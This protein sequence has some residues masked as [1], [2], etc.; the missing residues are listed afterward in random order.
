MNPDR[1]FSVL[2]CS[3][4][5]VALFFA[6]AG[7]ETQQGSTIPENGPTGGQEQPSQIPKESTSPEGPTRMVLVAAEEISAGTVLDE[8]IAKMAA[9]AVD[10]LPANPIFEGEE[11]YYRSH[12]IGEDL[13]KGSVLETTI[14]HLPRREPLSTL[15]S[16]GKRSVILPVKDADRLVDDITPGDRVDI[17]F[18]LDDANTARKL[19]VITEFDAD[20][21]A[22]VSL[23]EGFV[24]H[25]VGGVHALTPEWEDDPCP[26]ARS[27]TL[28]TSPEDARTLASLRAVADLE[29]RR[30]QSKANTIEGGN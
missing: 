19:P 3:L 24:V 29:I 13:P 21:G 17:I 12:I 14:F 15:T 20:G 26:D 10:E 16:Q 23:A 18:R 4:L 22:T 25:A 2:F 11:I 8:E 27:I 30:S 1:P 9:V 6:T 28:E 7:C 5:V